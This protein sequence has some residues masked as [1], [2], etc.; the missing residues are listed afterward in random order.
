LERGLAVLGTKNADAR[1]QRRTRSRKNEF[2]FLK[3]ASSCV[4]GKC[5]ILKKIFLSS[6]DFGAGATLPH[7]WTFSLSFV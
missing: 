7:F 1:A 3:L 2:G 4:F 6:E 5:V